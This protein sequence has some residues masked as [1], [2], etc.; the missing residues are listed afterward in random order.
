MKV[1]HE[2]FSG[3]LTHFMAYFR[4]NGRAQKYAGDEPPL[5]S[6]LFSRDQMKRHGKDMGFRGTLLTSVTNYL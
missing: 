6:E 3:I 4:R 5:R 1:S 2:T